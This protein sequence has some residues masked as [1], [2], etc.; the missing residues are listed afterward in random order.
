MEVKKNNKV[1]YH[2]QNMNICSDNTPFDEFVFA[3]HEPTKED[4]E[5]IIRDS[6][7]DAT[8]NEVDEFVNYSS[9]YKVYA[10]EV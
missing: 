4:L 5:K 3:D 10:E 8:D 2:I 6:L 7:E 1:L 9:V